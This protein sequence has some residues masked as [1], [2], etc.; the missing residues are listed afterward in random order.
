M[1]SGSE[2]KSKATI[3]STVG[4][5]KKNIY[6][7]L[8]KDED[9]ISYVAATKGKARTASRR[10]A[11]ITGD[12]M[13]KNINGWELKEKIGQNGIVHVKK[14][15]GATIRDVHSYAQSRREG[16]AGGQIAPGPQGLRGPMKFDSLRTTKEVR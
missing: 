9:L 12:S 16:G 7:S 8:N 5:S 10:S 11:V 3:N 15:N 6:S 2:T 1:T 14:F 13:I 4:D